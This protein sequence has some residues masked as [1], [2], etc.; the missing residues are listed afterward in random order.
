MGHR[1]LFTGL[2][3]YNSYEK[4][5]IYPIKEQM[6]ISLFTETRES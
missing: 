6:F 5:I 4:V 1:K 3:H 2:A